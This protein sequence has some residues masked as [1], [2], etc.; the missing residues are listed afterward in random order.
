[1]SPTLHLLPT[2]AVATLIKLPFQPN[3]AARGAWVQRLNNVCRL[4]RCLIGKMPCHVFNRKAPARVHGDLARGALRPRIALVQRLHE[5]LAT[6]ALLYWQDA[7]TTR[8][9]DK[10]TM[11]HGEGER[12]LTG[13]RV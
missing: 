12:E 9:I 6:V 2:N 13:C 10:I 4:W 5:V 7:N 8:F 11:P 3:Q 1:R